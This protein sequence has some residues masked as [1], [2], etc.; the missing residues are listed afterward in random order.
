MMVHRTRRDIK[1][2]R[3][4]YG[5]AWEEYEKAVPYLYIPVGL[6]N[7]QLLA[8]AHTLFS[9][10]SKAPALILNLAPGSYITALP[11]AQPLQ[12]PKQKKLSIAHYSIVIVSV[13]NSHDVLA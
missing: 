10:F 2:C 1:K 11:G 3:L 13:R 12:T 9:I 8:T 6:S 4:K 7:M 5:K